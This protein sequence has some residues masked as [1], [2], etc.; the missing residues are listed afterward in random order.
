MSFSEWREVNLEQISNMKYGKMPKKNKIIDKGYPIYTG[1]KIAGFYDEYMFENPELL[2]VARGVGGTGDVKIAPPKSYITNLSI[3][4]LLD[5]LKADKRYLFYNLGNE[6]LRVLDS[7]SAQSQITIAD[8]KRYKI[9]LPPLPEQKAIAHILSTLDEKIEVNNQ[10]NK[11]L[12]NIAQTIFKQWF[13]DFEFPNGAGEPYKSSGGEMVD[14]ELGMI[15]KGWEVSNYKNFINTIVGGD[16][17]KESIQGNYNKEVYCLRGADIP[18]VRVGRKGNLPRRYILEKNYKS[19][20][21]SAGN[22]VVEISGGSPT[23]STGRIT[24][25]T[26]EMLLKYD[27]DFVCTNFC[28][29]ITLI[30][31]S[32]M[33]YFYLSWHNLYENGVFFQYENGTTGIKNFDINT[34]IETYKILEPDSNTLIN[35]NKIISVLIKKIQINGDEN[36][37]LMNLRDSL[38]PKLMSGEIRVPIE[39]N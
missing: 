34:F 10:I 5:E 27:S 20:K 24:Y 4:L 17:G 29:A 6:N 33:E 26:N 12:E 30:D 15:P 38:L 31:N 18:E 36:I 7:G 28:R 19:K 14:S 3:I 9:T 22:L 21:L 35:F 37:K 1:Y 39:E 23:Q 25:I 8:L 2:V 32:I 16:W 13:V 11:T